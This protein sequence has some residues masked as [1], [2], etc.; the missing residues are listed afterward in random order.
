MTRI[1]AAVKRGRPKGSRN[2]ATL[3][4]LIAVA[5]AADAKV[6]RLF[7]DHDTAE[8]MVVELERRRMDLIATAVATAVNR[9][10]ALF[11]Q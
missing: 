5:N 7:M 10:E 1:N 3:G 6:L 2:K 4:K 8:K 9:G 11:Q